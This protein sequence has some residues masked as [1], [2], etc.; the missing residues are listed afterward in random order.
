VV[1]TVHDPA[2]SVRAE[3]LLDAVEE[4]RNAGAEALQLGD[5][6]VVASTYLVDGDGGVEVD[7]KLLRP[8]YVFRAVGDPGT[9]EPALRIRGGVV[10]TVARQEGADAAV[11][12]RERVE[13][14]ALRDPQPLE[15]AEPVPG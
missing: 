11:E 9:L 10:D 4:L 12:P 7:G 6:R 13:V 14:T 8:P 3:V 1:L 15:H 5:V 2:G